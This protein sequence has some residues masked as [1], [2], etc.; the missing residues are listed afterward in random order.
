MS[1]SSVNLVDRSAGI[2]AD[3]ARTAV[4]V[5]QVETTDAVNDT[6]IVVLTASGIPQRRT[7]HPTDTT[8]WVTTLSA[9]PF[10]DRLH[11]RVEVSYEAMTAG[12][13]GGEDHPWDLPAQV[14]YFVDR[15]Q[16]AISKAY[17]P[18][19]AAFAPTKPILNSAKDPFLDP[20]TL[21]KKRFGIRISKNIEDGPF[22]PD[23]YFGYI[24][25]L[26]YGADGIRVGGCNIAEKHGRI[27]DVRLDPQYDEENTLYWVLGIDIVLD[28]N[29]WVKSIF[30]QG[31]NTMDAVTGVKTRIKIEG[32]DAADPQPLNGAGQYRNPVTSPV[33][34]Y[35]DYQV[36]PAVD[37]TPLGLPRE[38]DGI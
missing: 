13:S 5:Y 17:D 34:V 1:V 35:L 21:D 37:W 7:V 8:L 24:D 22:D 14:S 29:D 15:E 32:R 4:R 25:T 12:A 11:W 20:M 16:Q 36:Y 23:A 31:F 10:Q 28:K 38:K 6:E 19:D 18:A 33:A 3:G 2:N 9:K 27:T 30:D 26:N